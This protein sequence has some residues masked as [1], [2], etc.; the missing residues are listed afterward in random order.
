MEDYQ[1]RL[2]VPSC[3]SDTI[4]GALPRVR[5]VGIPM[6]GKSQFIA[7]G[8]AAALTA[9]ADVQF[10]DKPYAPVEP[11]VLDTVSSAYADC[12]AQEADRVDDGKLSPIGLA[13][14]VI[15]ACEKQFAALEAVA[16]SGNGRLGRHAVRNGLEQDKEE[17]ATH[18]VLRERLSRALPH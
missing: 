12:L 14:K 16:S 3:Y 17:F 1:W 13:L 10:G 7:L 2:S 18:I 15:P 5:S 9:C 4:P 6:R 8:T 11:Q